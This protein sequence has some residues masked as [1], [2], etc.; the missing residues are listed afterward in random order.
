MIHYDKKGYKKNILLFI[1]KMP[2]NYQE[3]KIYYI[4]CYTTGLKYYGSTTK[5]YLSRRL[6]GHVYDYNRYLKGEMNFIT[7]FKVLENNNYDIVLVEKFPCNSKDE[8]LQRERYYIENNECVN[9]CIPIRT[10]EE[11][12]ELDKCYREKCKDKIKE[13]KEAYYKTNKEDINKKSKTYYEDNKEHLNI[14][15][16]EYAENHKD[17]IKIKKK[18]Y[19]IANKD[20]IK[21]Y[22]KQYREK[23]K[24]KIKEYQNSY[25]EIIK[26][27]TPYT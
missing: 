16:K 4:I 2:V 11:N 7:S 21:E 9:K 6:G 15:N 18:E 13:Y 10:I 3:S 23:N 27:A 20:K 19:A 22:Q 17:E 8:L 12:Y 26:G 14:I 1:I 5:K 24:D 25:K